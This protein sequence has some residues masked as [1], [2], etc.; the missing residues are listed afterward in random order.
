MEFRRVFMDVFH[1]QDYTEKGP[2]YHQGH[3][4][5]PLERPDTSPLGKKK[6]DGCAWTAKRLTFRAQGDVTW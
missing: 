6:N 1:F 3:K 2:N 5:L 4:Y